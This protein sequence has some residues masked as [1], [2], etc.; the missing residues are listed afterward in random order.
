MGPSTGANEPRSANW[1]A[2]RWQP[3]ASGQG[4]S[5]ESL[6][7]PH[8]SRG[9]WPRSSPADV[10][11]AFGAA[12]R[13]VVAWGR[14]SSEDRA[15][16]LLNSLERLEQAQGLADMVSA[17]LGLGPEE[18][19][20]LLQGDFLRARESLEILRE[21]VPDSSGSSGFFQA[22]WSDLAGCLHGRLAA[23]L[24]AGSTTVLLADP[25]LPE[26]AET[27]ARALEAAEVPPGVVNL[28]FD[29]GWTALRAALALR[30]LAWVR[31]RGTREDLRELAGPSRAGAFGSG[32]TSW[33]LWPL[34]SAVHVVGRSTDPEEEAE[35]VVERGLSPSATLCGQL[36]DRIGRVLCHQRQLSRFTEEL[37]T[38]LDGRADIARPRPL[39]EPGLYDWL[40]EA[41]SLGLDEGAAPILGEAPGDAVRRGSQN[42]GPEPDTPPGATSTEGVE[43]G[44]GSSD[45]LRRTRPLRAAGPVVFTNVEAGGR[46]SRLE[47]PAPLLRLVRVA[48]DEEAHALRRELEG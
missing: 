45:E 40:G 34:T 44:T 24:L 39:V 21:G 19:R 27:V 18:S 8:R 37:L 7:A 10:E 35:R 36:P 43:P 11:L 47:R 17:G 15:R 30:A 38:R 46:L 42:Q 31:L 33:T 12:R 13:A 32:L 1:I 22:H 4:F 25:R 28:V 48:S 5:V 20:A 29:D 2:G 26:A 9:T 41:W 3:S 14:L 16:L 6:L 23:R